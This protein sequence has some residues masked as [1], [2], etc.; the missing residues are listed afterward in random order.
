MLALV[1]GTILAALPVQQAVPDKPP[2]AV[3]ERE[4]GQ[5]ALSTH[6]LYL[7]IKGA[8][9]FFSGIRVAVVVDREVPCS[10]SKLFAIVTPK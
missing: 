4:A 1:L 9:F 6:D 3:S 5:H 2:I 8:R 10:P 7:R